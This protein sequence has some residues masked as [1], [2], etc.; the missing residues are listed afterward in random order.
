MDE[1]LAAAAGD[2]NKSGVE[3]VEL[4]GVGENVTAGRGA[5]VAG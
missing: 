4:C 5:V 2:V 3:L 1:A